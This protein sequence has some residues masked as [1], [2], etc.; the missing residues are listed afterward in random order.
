MSVLPLKAPQQLGLLQKKSQPRRVSEAHR[1]SAVSAAIYKRWRP[2]CCTCQKDGLEQKRTEE[3]ERQNNREQTKAG[4]LFGKKIFK[5]KRLDDAI[6]QIAS[7]KDLC[8]Q[9]LYQVIFLPPIFL[10]HTTVPTFS[11]FRRLINRTKNG[12]LKKPRDGTRLFVL[13]RS[14]SGKSFY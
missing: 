2:P 12:A 10:P 14:R 9:F 4:K 3:T 8:H 11:R 6:V 7:S 1:S 13:I 5:N